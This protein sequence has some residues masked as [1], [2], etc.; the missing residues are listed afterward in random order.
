GGLRLRTQAHRGFLTILEAPMAVKEEID[1]WGYTGNALPLM[2]AIKEQ[3]DSKNILSPGR[4][5][6]GI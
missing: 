3:F 1:V 6:G 5:V 2:L 4:F